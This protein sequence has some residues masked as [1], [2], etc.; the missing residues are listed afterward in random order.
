MLAQLAAFVGI[1]AVVIVTPGPDTALTI[2]NALAGGRRS[3]IMTA[4]GVSLGQGVWTLAASAGVVAVFR[5][6]EPAFLALQ[7]VGTAYLVYLGSKSLRA[8]FRSRSGDGAS[9]MLSPRVP[10]SVALRQGL[11]SNLSNPKMAAFFTSLLPQFAPGGRGSFV[12]LLLL[13]L[14]FCLMTLLWLT[15][16]SLAVA[17]ARELLTRPRVRRMLDALLGAVLIAFGARLATERR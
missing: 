2:R 10:A 14:L 16:Y 5:A 17:K 6:S 11:I 4:A 15:A 8:A 3:G 7:I 12:A 13:G 1:S 9:V